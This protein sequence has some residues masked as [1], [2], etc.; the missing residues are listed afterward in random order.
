L[1]IHD[2]KGQQV[3]CNVSDAVKSNI[4]ADLSELMH[5]TVAGKDTTNAAS[6]VLNYTDI[7]KYCDLLG[8][9]SKL[10]TPSQYFDF[11]KD[12]FITILDDSK[13][14][15]EHLVLKALM[16]ASISPTEKDWK[17]FSTKIESK[18]RVVL[19]IEL[20]DETTRKLSVATN[21][22][23][24]DNIRMAV[25]LILFNFYTSKLP[26]LLSAK[27]QAVINLPGNEATSSRPETSIGDARKMVRVI[28]YGVKY[29]NDKETAKECHL[30]RYTLLD[31]PESDPDVEL[32]KLF[33]D[34]S[35]T[36]LTLKVQILF[37]LLN[38]ITVLKRI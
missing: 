28:Q 5:A 4:L 9:T 1:K 2:E 11:V 21:T 16:I 20:E 14:I 30:F 19:N 13:K 36:L 6:F 34:R 18:S 8:R 35:R 23:Q 12:Q 17:Q 7:E 32:A 38:L 10:I 26:W 31:E 22:K 37:L 33:L 27:N 29:G 25:Y 3:S 24:A 15:P